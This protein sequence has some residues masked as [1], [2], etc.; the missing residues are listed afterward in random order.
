MND[1]INLTMNNIDKEHICC[2]IG[3]PKHQKG[4]FCKKEWT[5][6]KLKD[7]HV[8]RKLNERGKVF[9]EYEPL[10]TAWTPISGDNYMYIYCLWVSGKFKGKGIAKE[11][12]EYAI[13]DSKEKGMNGIC[14]LSSKK[15]KPFLSEKKFFEHYIEAL[16]FCYLN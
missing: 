8:F 16:L 11:L 14:I 7:G 13:N 1:Y 3:D 2:A 6:S 5:K 4:V 15:K 10:N 9:I 12:L